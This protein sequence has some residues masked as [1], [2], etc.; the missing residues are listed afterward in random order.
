LA[1]SADRVLTREEFRR[2]MGSFVTGVAVV[3]TTVDGEPHGMTVN[4]LTSVS[5]EPLLLLVCLTI[6]TRTANAVDRSGSFAINLLSQH[7][8]DIADIFARPGGDHFGGCRYTSPARSSR[9]SR[10]ET[11][12][13]SSASR[14]EPPSRTSTRSS[15]I[16]VDTTS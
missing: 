16:E 15:F 9:R 1:A 13:S 14:Y 8:H 5:L 4:S 11:T 3:T 2:V 12:R 7:Q 10:A 6:G